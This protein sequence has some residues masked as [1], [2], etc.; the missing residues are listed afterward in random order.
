MLDHSVSTLD[1]VSVHRVGN[2]NNDEELLIS[3]HRLDISDKSV[4]ELLQK[5]FL[6]QFK[7][8]E[9]FNFTFSNDD[10]NMNP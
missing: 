3:K 4:E 5:F 6:N 9:Y 8:E 7:S 2:K 1:E 10:F